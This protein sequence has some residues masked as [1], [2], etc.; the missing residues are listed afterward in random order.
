MVIDVSFESA[1]TGICPLCPWELLNRDRVTWAPPDG[2]VVC[3]GRAVDFGH[4]PS[5]FW[6]LFPFLGSEN[7]GLMFKFLDCA[8]S[9]VTGEV[10]RLPEAV[11]GGPTQGQQARITLPGTHALSPPTRLCCSITQTRPSWTAAPHSCACPRRCSTR[12]W[13]RWPARLW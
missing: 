7:V 8:M 9:R 1:K 11:C 13:R 2:A 4:I 12:W 3:E 6:T 5:L 10:P